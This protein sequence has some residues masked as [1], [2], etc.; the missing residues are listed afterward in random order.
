MFWKPTI[1]SALLAAA[2]VVLGAGRAPTPHGVPGSPPGRYAT[3]TFAGGCFWSMEHPFDQ[4]RGV[5]AVTVG[6]TGGQTTH[7]TYDEV[8]A[9]KTGHAESV[10]VQYDPSQIGYEA[11]LDVFWHNIDP[12]TRDGQVCDFGRQYRTAIFYHDAAQR[13]LAEASKRQLEAS[14]RFQQP[15]VTELVAAGEFYP[16]EAYHQHYYRTHPQQYGWYREACGR[17][18]RLQEVWGVSAPAAAHP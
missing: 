18:R 17:D 8:S 7:P 4:L 14:G 6:Y 16:A 12:L 9:G 11:L 10:Q 3:A 15:I 2:P 1:V 13:G 5:V